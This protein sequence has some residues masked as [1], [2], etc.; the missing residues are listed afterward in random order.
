MTTMSQQ[1]QPPKKPL[2]DQEALLEA[3]RLRIKLD[4]V[5]RLYDADP[6]T[7]DPRPRALPSVPNLPLPGSAGRNKFG[8]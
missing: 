7:V 2:L 8:V 4:Q 6:G 5:R 3:L 1:P